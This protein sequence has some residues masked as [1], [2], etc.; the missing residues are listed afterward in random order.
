MTLCPFALITGM[1]CPGCGMTRAL[2]R[3][4]RGDLAGAMS[5]HPLILLVVVLGAGGVVWAAGRK[6][7]GWRP[8]PER[9][10]NLGLAAVF[11][12]FLATW[13]IRMATSTL[14]PV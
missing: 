1:A 14:P 9:V 3:L 2:G 7:R 8:L 11:L 12:A 5:F 10:L 13:L 4:L 6:W